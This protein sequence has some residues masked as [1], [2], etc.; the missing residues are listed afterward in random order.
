MFGLWGLV[1]GVLLLAFGVFAVFFFPSSSTHQESELAIGGVI[2]GV[3]SLLI[4][5]ALVFL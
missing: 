2:M 3:I 1:F 4:G 5:A